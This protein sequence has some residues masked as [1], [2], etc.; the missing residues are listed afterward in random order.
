MNANAQQKTIKRLV[1]VMNQA[2]GTNLAEGELS[3]VRRLDELVGFDS[4]TLLQWVA[5][6][7]E[8]FQVAF[9]PEQLRLE[10]LVDLGGL[11]KYLT[12]VFTPSAAGTAP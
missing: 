8:E 4:M 6:L 7:E 9:P 5:G 12:R 10:F 3:G 1:K 2:L 11:A